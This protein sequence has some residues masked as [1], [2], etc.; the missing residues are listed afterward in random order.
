[1][2]RE[3]Q[4]PSSVLRLVKL[5][6]T[7]GVGTQTGRNFKSGKIVV[8]FWTDHW[9]G[10]SLDDRH[11]VFVVRAITLLFLNP[12]IR[13]HKTVKSS[14]KIPAGSFRSAGDYCRSRCTSELTC[15]YSRCHRRPSVFQ[16]SKIPSG[17][18]KRACWEDGWRTDA[19]ISGIR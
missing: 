4:N 13:R 3:I 5:F 14:Q 15:L 11:F 9:P 12:P 1:M 8:V 18:N 10:A 7:P 2:V 16:S 17:A 19:G 6:E